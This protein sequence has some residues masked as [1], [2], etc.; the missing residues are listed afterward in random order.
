MDNKVFEILIALYFIFAF[1]GGILKK[2]K[3]E[4]EKAAR[5]AIVPAPDS[6]SR[7]EIKAK[8]NR[9]TQEMLNKLLG[10]QISQPSDDSDFEDEITEKFIQPENAEEFSTW[11]PE[12]EFKEEEE[13]FEGIPAGRTSDPLAEKYRPET[14]ASEFR[15][16]TLVDEV[17]FGNSSYRII[18][19]SS[20]SRELIKK[21]K[22]PA[23]LK[24]A[25]LLAEIIGKPKALR[26]N[27]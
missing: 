3:K 12:D 21:L 14:R 8:R 13:F 23:K 4:R 11:D 1:I 26:R 6:V 18:T 27:G 20:Y 5:R 7:D 17:D 16:P 10:V 24:E 22:N 25:I 19:Q 15:E 2:K 9:D